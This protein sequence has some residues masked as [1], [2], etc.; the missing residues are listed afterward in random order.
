M[1]DTGSD[2]EKAATW[3]F[4]SWLTLSEQQAAWHIGTGYIPIAP[5]AAEHP[6][7]VA[8]WSERPGFRVA[9]D[10]LASSE[11][12]P[13]PVLGGYPGFREAVTQ[14][15]ER[16]ADGTDPAESLAT[17][18]AEATQAIQDYNRRVG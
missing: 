11:G 3:D 10:Q 1:V 2:E 9:F 15:L 7:V 16:V 13:G 5:S 6:D 18:D 8:L 4:A 14:G 17:A 12:P